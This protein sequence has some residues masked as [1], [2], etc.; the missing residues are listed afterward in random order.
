[1]DEG[2]IDDRYEGFVVERMQAHVKS[3]NAKGFMDRISKDPCWWMPENMKTP[4]QCPHL[5]REER[6][7]GKAR[8]RGGPSQSRTR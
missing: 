2:R 6:K 4:T 7:N 5:Y 1:M 3:Y 8:T